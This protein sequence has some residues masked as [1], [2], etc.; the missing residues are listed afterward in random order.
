VELFTEAAG[1]VPCAGPSALVPVAE[2]FFLESV[3]ADFD[4]ASET[5]GLSRR[6]H[7]AWLAPQDQ[8]GGGQGAG[9]AG[10]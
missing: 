1:R 8:A 2:Y 6:F 10:R 9:A 3:L 4:L 5:Y 7:H